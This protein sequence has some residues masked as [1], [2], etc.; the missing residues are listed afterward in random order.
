MATNTNKLNLKKPAPEDFY[1]VEDFNENFQKIDDFLK[2]VNFTENGGS[3]IGFSTKT[4]TGGA[5]GN[6]S[7]TTT[8][9]AI[10][11]GADSTTGGAIGHD[12]ETTDGGA[13]GDSAKAKNGGGA[14]GY[15][16]SSTTGGAIGYGA[17]TSDGFSG[18]KNA[19][20][21]DSSNN[22]IDAVQ[23]GTG[24]N[25]NPK[26]LKVYDYQLLDSNGE[27]PL[28]R[29]TKGTRIQAGT[30]TG[31]GGVGSSLP[32]KL[33]FEGKPEIVIVSDDFAGTMR[34]IML[35]RG[36]SSATKISSVFINSILDDIVAQWDD[37]SV[38]WYYSKQSPSTTDA[39][40][41]LNASGVI[42]TYKAFL[43]G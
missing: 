40:N 29:M 5:V 10:G 9:G 36:L 42:Y 43:R 26:T 31:T 19:K 27:I 39:Y 33:T 15:K 23:L 12:T 17:M 38:S 13:V 24:I 4:T 2:W 6:A 35:I 11:Y 14:V 7:T 16:T 18:G 41:Q 3:A 20:T 8:G 32:N 30:Y 37:N 34:T 1:N 22:L 21:V 28:E 25:K